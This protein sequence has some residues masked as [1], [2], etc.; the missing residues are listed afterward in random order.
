VGAQ[1]GPPAPRDPALATA[2]EPSGRSV[3]E[4]RLVPVL[5]DDLPVIR[6]VP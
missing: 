1:S 3:M 5:L 4:E 6:S 2:L